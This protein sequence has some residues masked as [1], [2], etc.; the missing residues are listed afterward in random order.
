[1]YMRTLGG[2]GNLTQNT[3]LR[4]LTFQPKGVD[5]AVGDSSLGVLSRSADELRS[6]FSTI[7]SRQLEHIV[8]AASRFFGKSTYEELIGVDTEG[9]DLRRLHEV[10][11]QPYFGSLKDVK[12]TID[13][14]I[15]LH[16]GKANTGDIVR[17]LEAVLRRL[18]QPWS[19]HGIVDVT[20]MDSRG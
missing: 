8:V 18:L 12:V 11:S 13:Y 10:M 3:A 2:H 20:W 6:V 5:R 16:L 17:K 14:P 1:M 19:D 15:N 9:L 7:H 4:S